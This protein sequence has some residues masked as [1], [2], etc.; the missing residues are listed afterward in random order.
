MTSVHVAGQ[1]RQRGLNSNS[2]ESN[3]EMYLIEI[4]FILEEATTVLAV[5][6]IFN[7]MKFAFVNAHEG[8]V[9]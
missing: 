8:I 2:K 6:V 3:A 7:M 5:I 4:V 1:C 9:A